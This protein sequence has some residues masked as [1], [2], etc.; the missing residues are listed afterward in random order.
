M[1][2]II[3]STPVKDTVT[4]RFMRSDLPGHIDE[5]RVTEEQLRWL[6]YNIAMGNYSN[7]DA[8][9]ISDTGKKSYFRPD[10]RLANPIE[11]NNTLSFNSKL[12]L[13]LLELMCGK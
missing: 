6:Q 9:V 10:G 3:E 2:E 5:I 4:V 11:G 7:K 8:V 13:G 1:Y 12:S